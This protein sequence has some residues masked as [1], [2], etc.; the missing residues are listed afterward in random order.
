[1]GHAAGRPLW[2]EAPEGYQIVTVRR[3]GRHICVGFGPLLDSQDGDE[4]QHG[5]GHEQSDLEDAQKGNSS[6]SSAMVQVSSDLSSQPF[7]ENTG[8]GEPL[9]QSVP[10]QTFGANTPPLSLLSYG[11]EENQFSRNL[12][13]PYENYEGLSQ[14]AS[15]GCD[16]LNGQ[17]GISF[18]NIDSYEPDSSDGEEDDAQHEHSLSREETSRYQETLDSILSELE[19][20]IKCFTDLQ[21]QLCAFNY[22]ASGECCEETALVPL[23]R[24][25]NIDADL[26]CSNN[27]YFLCS[28]ENQDTP[29]GNPSVDDCEVQQNRNVKDVG[30]GTSVGNDNEL[31]VSEGPPE[32]G[33]S[34]NLVVRPKT[35]KQ[36]TSNQLEREKLPPS[37]DEG[38]SGS[39]ERNKTAESQQGCDEYAL[40]MSKEERCSNWLFTLRECEGRRENTDIDVR[41]KAAAQEMA[42]VLGVREKSENY[43]K[44]A[45]EVHKDEDSSGCSDGEWPSAL[46]A[47]FTA[48]EKEQCSSD[49]SLITVPGAEEHDLETRS[50]SSSMEEENIDLC[51]HRRA[52]PFLEEGEMPCLQYHQEEEDS[53]SDEESYPVSSFIHPGFFMLG[54]NYNFEDD[55]SVSEDLDVEWRTLD[56]F[57]DILGLAQT[58]SY[59]DPQYFTLMAMEG[60]MQAGLEAALEQLEAFAFS[61]DEP[62]PPA[63]KETIDSLPEL[64]LMENPDGQEQCSICCSNYVKDEVVTELPCRHFFHKL[65]VSVWLQTSGTCPICRHVLEP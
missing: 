1:M 14:Y 12:V 34:A 37:D 38:E 32:Q 36:N 28:A 53:S 19:K 48:A 45:A 59:V 3:Y 9:C 23:M 31:N 49:E 30:I 52:H 17:N 25:F 16:A 29:T 2:P 42:S 63:T 65:C 54:G 64:T 62:L 46:V 40:Q 26:P 11:Q 6:G 55:S 33:N 8:A 21:S 7:L 56:E 18:V 41:K 60:Q 39:R 5:G 15:G 20:G 35:R 10:S 13:N 58:L 24:Y 22:S 47:Y 27:R 57:G 4:H 43:R 61:P 50:S 51:F 44:H